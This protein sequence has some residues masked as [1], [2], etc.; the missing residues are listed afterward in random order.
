[1]DTAFLLAVERACTGANIHR[2]RNLLQ[3][4]VGF[5]ETGRRDE[6]EKIK[7]VVYTELGK[8]P[9]NSTIQA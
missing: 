8:T 3:V 5:T 4:Y 2:M 9:C 1:V 7:R 6:A